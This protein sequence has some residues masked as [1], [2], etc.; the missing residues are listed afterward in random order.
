MR[1]L[2]E[3]FEEKFKDRLTYIKC[4]HDSYKKEVGWHRESGVKKEKWIY[5]ICTKCGKTIG[6]LPKL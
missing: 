3:E 5:M 2:E 6:W 1:N 4:P